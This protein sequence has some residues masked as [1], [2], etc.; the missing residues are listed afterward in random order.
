M[1]IQRRKKFFQQEGDFLDGVACQWD[2]GNEEEDERRRG[3]MEKW[4]WS[5]PREASLTSTDLTTSPETPLLASAEGVKAGIKQRICGTEQPDG[6]GNQNSLLWV[7]AGTWDRAY[8]LGV[9]T[10]PNSN[11]R[12]ESRSNSGVPGEQWPPL[13]WEDIKRGAP[14]EDGIE[15]EAG[16]EGHFSTEYIFSSLRKKNN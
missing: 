10:A 1:S 16:Q 14:D 3:R 6:G 11:L 13:T 12:V 9:S 7:L 4:G 5:E 15:V 2:S 8:T